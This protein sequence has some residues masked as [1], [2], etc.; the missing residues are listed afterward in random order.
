M[1][2][3]PSP[4]P[5]A[6]GVFF[7]YAHAD[8]A[9]RDELARH[10]R[11]MERQGIIA[12]WHD[13]RI[14]PGGE[15]AGAIDAHLQRAQIILL[16]VSA[17]FLASDYCFNLEVQQAMAR[18][19]AG[20]ARVIPVIMRQCDWHSAPFGM[21]QALPTDGRP[22]VNWPDRD[23]AFLN[24]ARGIRAV[25]EQMQV[26]PIR[27]FPLPSDDAS[28]RNR[29]DGGAPQRP[30]SPYPGL[31]PF[32]TDE[33][34]IFFGRARETD[35]LIARLRD[36]DCRFLAVVGTS[37]TGRSSL[38][39][40]GVL[41]RLQENAVDGSAT[42]QIVSFQPGRQGP[43]PFLAVA[44]ELLRLLPQQ[45]ILPIRLAEEL[46]KDPATVAGYADQ[47]LI[48]RPTSARLMLFVD[49]LEELFTQVAGNYRQKFVDLLQEAVRHPRV[50]VLVALRADSL[51]QFLE[52]RQSSIE[53]FETFPLAPPGPTALTDMI[54]RPAQVAGVTLE[55]GVADKILED[56][57]NDRGALP[58]VAF[59]LKELYDNSAPEH[60]I[61]LRQYQRMGGL[62]EAIG[63]HATATM[64]RI[65]PGGRDDI[66]EILFSKLVTVDRDGHAVRRRVPHAELDGNDTVRRLAEEL[67]KEPGWLLTRTEHT[68]ELSHD[69]LLDNWRTLKEWIE[70][71]RADMRLWAELE[72]DAKNWRSSSHEDSL[73]WKGRKLQE[74]RK[75]LKRAPPYL[76]EEVTIDEMKRFIQASIMARWKTR[77]YVSLISS[78]LS[79]LIAAVA[80]A[81]IMV[82]ITP[83]FLRTAMPGG[84]FGDD[85]PFGL[86]DV[87]GN[88]W[89]WT[90]DC[91]EVPSMDRSA[92]AMYSDNWCIARG[93]SWDNHED[94][95]VRASYPLPLAKTHTVRTVG[96][97]VARTV[98]GGEPR[99]KVPN[100]EECF[101]DCIGC[102]EMVILPGGPFTVRRPPRE[103]EGCREEHPQTVVAIDPF[104]IG[105]YEVMVGEWNKCVSSPVTGKKCKEKA[106][107]NQTDE[108]RPIMNV[109]WED[110]QEY[111]EWLNLYTKKQYR[112]P[113]GAEWEYAARGNKDT[114]RWWGNELGRGKANCAA[115]GL[116]WK[117]FFDWLFTPVFQWVK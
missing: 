11:L 100:C 109:S 49:Q 31:R 56:A 2:A 64:E 10:L 76:P 46:E 97:R 39:Y 67:S 103:T 6:I 42:W 59:C 47:A 115:C 92:R 40:A 108:G 111:V 61:T 90:E 16:L 1:A 9:L 37:G 36:S 116:T 53:T 52:L 70:R 106:S 105:R 110:A 30:G 114:C 85:H 34:Q 45:T 48:E 95:K 77:A 73:L 87:L 94:W 98:D 18:H 74:A 35:A 12:G 22:I 79:V 80:F 8:E 57:G 68:V 84:S 117:Q 99:G 82:Y 51:P 29:D 66:L 96:F 102:P 32:R 55:D 91:L 28:V 7:S 3:T 50:Q 15:W 26:L 62:H 81:V 69:A 60:R 27:V 21:L 23:E 19:D 44:N 43:N 4:P 24:V 78:A 89:E 25:A 38:V 83:S 41:P 20:E 104:A 101:S 113:S 14:P 13:R 63:M 112:L 75:L 58:L 88:V 54:R 86:Y 33:S 5:R 93:G 71:N 72:H 107:E 65:L 17:D